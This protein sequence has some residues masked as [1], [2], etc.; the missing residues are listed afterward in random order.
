[1]ARE[2]MINDVLTDEE[3]AIVDAWRRN[4]DRFSYCCDAVAIIDRLSARLAVAERALMY[5]RKELDSIAAQHS[6]CNIDTK[7][8]NAIAAWEFAKE[9]R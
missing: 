6:C 9:R 3:R 5:T 2:G 4:A 8:I 1:M 7:V